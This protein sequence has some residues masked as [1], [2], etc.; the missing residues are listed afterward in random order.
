MKPLFSKFN[1]ILHS[2]MILSAVILISSCGTSSTDEKGNT[3]KKDTLVTD[4]AE[5]IELEEVEMETVYEITNTKTNITTIMSQD[6]YLESAIWENPDC[7]VKELQ[8][9]K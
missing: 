5:M 6:E 4:Q 9:V 3:I 1:S 2:T 7:V 8:T